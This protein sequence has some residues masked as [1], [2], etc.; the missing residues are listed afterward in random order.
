[1]AIPTIISDIPVHQELLAEGYCKRIP[2]Q[3][4]IPAQHEVVDETRAYV[5]YGM[6]HKIAVVD[7]LN[8]IKDVYENYN[9]YLNKAKK[10]AE[11]IRTKWKNEDNQ[12]QIKILLEHLK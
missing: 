3:G 12:Y 4:W 8:A 9:I 5:T 11:W 1:M 6:W 10:G 7:I 2:H